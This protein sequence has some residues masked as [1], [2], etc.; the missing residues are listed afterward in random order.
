[1][2]IDTDYV[3]QLQQRAGSNLQREIDVSLLAV[4]NWQKGIFIPANSLIRPTIANQ[5]GFVYQNVAAGQTGSREPAWPASGTVTDGSVTW[6]PIAPPASSEDTVQSATWTQVSPPDGLLAIT[7][8]AT[9]SLTASAYLGGGT[10]GFVYSVL[11]AITMA[12]GAV[13][14]VLLY[15]TIL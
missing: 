15:L 2:S 1:M 3:V 13:I 4:E 5:T 8:E 6:T 14:Q 11:V 7:G 10:S 9:S 12:S